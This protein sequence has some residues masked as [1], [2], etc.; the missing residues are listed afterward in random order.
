MYYLNPGTDSR[1][2]L[3]AATAVKPAGDSHGRWTDNV[4]PVEYFP[5]DLVGAA[6]SSGERPSRSILEVERR[7]VAAIQYSR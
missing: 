6:L 1:I 3:R 5:N 2:Y 4:K 7:C